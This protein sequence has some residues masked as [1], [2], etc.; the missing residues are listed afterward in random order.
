[1]SE[2]LA[3]LALY[4]LCDAT[5]VMRPMSMEE[6][7]ACTRTYDAV[8]TYFVAEFDLAPPGSLERFQQMNDAYIAFSAWQAANPDLVAEMR[9]QAWDQVHRYL[10]T[11][12]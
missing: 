12:G 6:V 3:I 9:Q 8:K 1:M 5:A 2:F 4:Y 10:P 11:R 7:Q